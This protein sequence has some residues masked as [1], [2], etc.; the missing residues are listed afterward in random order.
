MSPVPIHHLALSEEWDSAV[1]AGV[2][3]VSTRGRSL[4]EE[5]FIHCSFAAQVA[6]VAS[7]FYADAA[8]LLLLT[9]DPDRLGVELRVEGGFPHV[10]GPVPVAAVVDVSPYP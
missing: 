6:G 7:A 9:I 10:Y 4:E 1:A 3:T 2:Y 5:G 8:S